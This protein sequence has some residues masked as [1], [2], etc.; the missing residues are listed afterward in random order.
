MTSSL[1]LQ[2]WCRKL[3]NFR[4]VYALDELPQLPLG[5]HN[6][7]VNTDT[8]NLSG[9]HWLAIRICDFNAWFFDPQF[10]SFPNPIIYQHLLN[11]CNVTCINEWQLPIQP[12]NSK[13]CGQHCV[14][15]LY[16]GTSAPSEKIV[17]EFIQ[18]LN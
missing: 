4:G 17:Q 8:R 5:F 16:H 10:L 2:Y 1:Q 15:F 12:L 9:T 11:S 14:Y 6:L 3:N 18:Q 13:L 7:I